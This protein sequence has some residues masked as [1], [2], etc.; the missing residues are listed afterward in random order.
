MSRFAPCT[1]LKMTPWVIV[2]T[3]ALAGCQTTTN[4]QRESGLQTMAPVENINGR[5]ANTANDQANKQS[6]P[7]ANPAAVAKPAAPVNPAWD[8]FQ[9][10]EGLRSTVATLQG[11]V[12]EQQQVIDRL[13][14]DS[15]ARY[16]DLDQRIELLN[17]NNATS[18]SEAL[19]NPADATPTAPAAVATLA[20]IEAQKKAYLAAYQSFR[21]EGPAAA[22]V[23]MDSF[24]K[25]YPDSVFVANAYYWLGE[26]HL[27]NTPADLDAASAQFNRV[28]GDYEGSP[29]VASS[30]YKLGTIADLKDQ[31][32]EAR[33]LMQTVVNRFPD[34]AEAGL[35]TGYLTA[36]P[37]N[38]T[39]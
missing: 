37:A 12:E 17:Q 33:Q 9:Q 32:N 14:E 31:R 7:I 38:V 13:Q 21:S 25:Q 22:I 19:I 6:T 27:A 4:A 2:T 35:A 3:L 20:D 11:R 29:K 24:I 23:S 16:T 39:R 10:I 8:M 1:A 30:Y 15:R 18:A 28:I 5:R 34:S 26:F 36:N